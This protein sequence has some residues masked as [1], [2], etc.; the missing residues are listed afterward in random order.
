MPPKH[1]SK[2]NNKKKKEKPRTEKNKK[3][4]ITEQDLLKI[5]KAK[6][7]RSISFFYK[8]SEPEPEEEPIEK[9]TARKKKE[10]KDNTFV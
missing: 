9:K 7:D 5:Q 2:S 1:K 4:T 6:E 3:Q 8:L 10:L